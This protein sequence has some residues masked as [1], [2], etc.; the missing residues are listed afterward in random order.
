MASSVI[1]SLG[2]PWMMV[3]EPVERWE[4]PPTTWI[5]ATA[6][7]LP[8]GERPTPYSIC[9]FPLWRRPRLLAATLAPIP[10]STS[11]RSTRASSS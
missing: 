11:S 8:R 4:M 5:R 7:V 1:G 9:P 2:P 6:H 3:K 10:I